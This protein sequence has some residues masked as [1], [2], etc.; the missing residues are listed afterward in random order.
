MASSID[1]VQLLRVMGS[2]LTAVTSC[3]GVSTATFAASM[4]SQ[5]SADTSLTL[6][7][8][9]IITALTSALASVTP[10]SSFNNSIVNVELGAVDTRAIFGAM[11]SIITAFSS[12]VGTTTGNFA[13]AMAAQVTAD[14]GLTAQEKAMITVVTTGVASSTPSAAAHLMA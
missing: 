11:V 8:K 3:T 5:A 1:N 2:I 9:A 6:G 7:E 14:T 4:A 12:A 13:T 10:S